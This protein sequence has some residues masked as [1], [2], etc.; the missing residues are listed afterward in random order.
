MP[1]RAKGPPVKQKIK[2]V[3]KIVV[4]SSGKGG[5]GKSTVAVGL[6]LA[7]RED[8][9]AGAGGL[10]EAG[11]GGVQGH[12]KIGLLDLDIFGPSVPKLMGLEGVGE[13]LLSDGESS[14]WQGIVGFRCWGAGLLG[15][16][17]SGLGVGFK[18]LCGVCKSVF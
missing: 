13:P 16:V 1:R 7:L 8:A 11:A 12:K 3:R 9:S 15:L 10:G 18:W 2:G 17:G 4:V 6:A 5:V 14:V